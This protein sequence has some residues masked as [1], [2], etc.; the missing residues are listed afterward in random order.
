MIYT[1]SGVVGGS[2]IG[3]DANLSVMGAFQYVQEA[4]TELMGKLKIDGI[5]S[6]K[7]YNA[8]WVITK[9]RIKMLKPI[10]WGDDYVME[11][12]ISS[13]S[14]V[15]LR[16][17]TAI[18]NATGEIVVYSATELCALDL[19]T[20]KIRKTSTVGVDEGT[21]KEPSPMEIFFTKF[22]ANDLPKVD[23]VTVR[24]TNVDMS[25]HTNNVEYIRFLLNTY[26]VSELLKNPIKEIEIY[27]ANQSFENEELQIFKLTN[28]NVDTFAIKRE[29]QSIIKCQIIH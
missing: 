28:D 26:P 5:T 17:D 20:G 8:L 22:N 16:I 1:K 9:N 21:Q 23:N 18:K 19:E 3:A 7:R 12:F 27:Y 11:S 6:K 4:V 10:A 14:L 13:I 2:F 24:S 15:T 29:D 25:L